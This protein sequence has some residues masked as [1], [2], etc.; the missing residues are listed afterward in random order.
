MHGLVTKQNTSGMKKRI[1]ISTSLTLRAEAMHTSLNKHSMAN[2]ILVLKS[3]AALLCKFSNEMDTW[4]KMC[5]F[6]N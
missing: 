4:I 1:S 3:R 6:W 2:I 5:T